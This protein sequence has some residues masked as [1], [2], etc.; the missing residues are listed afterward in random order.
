[1][2]TGLDETLAEAGTLQVSG[3]TLENDI[4]GSVMARSMTPGEIE[5]DQDHADKESVTY[6]ANQ[7]VL[8]PFFHPSS[9]LSRIGIART[10]YFPFGRRPRVIQFALLLLAVLPGQ[11]L[12]EF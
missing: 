3:D 11:N 1:M 5:R 6:H 4:G 12:P 9:L 8:P 10:S 2:G 7:I